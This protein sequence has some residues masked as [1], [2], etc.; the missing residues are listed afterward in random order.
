M[1]PT[2][3]TGAIDLTI[4]ASVARGWHVLTVTGELDLA[5]SP[6]LTQ[7]LQAVPDSAAVALDLSEVTF[8]DSSGLGAIVS[9]N[10]R[11]T[12]RG[13]RLAVIAPE[14]GPVDR[15]VALTGL[16]QIVAVVRS[17]GDLGT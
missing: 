11:L 10:G 13:G 7:R 12:D 16:D 3:E 17:R 1:T 14:R 15:L 8:I 4:A 6:L 9:A 5:S 2:R